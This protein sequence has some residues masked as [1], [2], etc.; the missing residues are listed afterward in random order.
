MENRTQLVTVKGYSSTPV[1][2]P[3]GVPQG[4]H[5]GPLFFGVFINDLI[6]RISSPSLLYA[7]DL[8]IFRQIDAVDQ[9]MHLQ[10]D[11]HKIQEWCVHNKM[12]LNVDKCYIISFTRKK[13]KILHLYSIRDTILKRV[14][15]VRDLGVLMDEQLTFRP[16]YDNILKKKSC[17][18][19]FH[20]KVN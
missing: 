4:S 13:N 20:L 14:E 8:K 1:S 6:Y 5:L 7:D 10:N 15:V 16:H 2:V 18:P 17:H 12:I 19:G 3:S 9:C 11:L